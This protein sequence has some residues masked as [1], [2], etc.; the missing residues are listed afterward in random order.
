MRRLDTRL[1]GPVL[2]EPDIHGDARGFFVESYRANVW[3]EHGIQG[4][5]VQDNH[6][7]SGQGVLR[8]MHFSI[9]EGQAKL[10]RCARGRILDVVV[11]LRRESETY[12]EWEGVE[13]DDVHARQLFVPVGFA[14]G[15]C[16]L[17][18][19]ADVTY[20]CSTYY[21]PDVERGFRYDDPEIAIE[22]PQDIA[23]LVSDR[24]RNAPTLADIAGDL[25]F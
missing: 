23:L 11:D 5:F 15:F 14:H 25:P 10:V 18:E 16:V 9:G 3:A 12:G 21:D 8:G 17:S 2:L 20:K 22:W 4:E 24:D 7:R 1:D 13:L 6:S 19:I